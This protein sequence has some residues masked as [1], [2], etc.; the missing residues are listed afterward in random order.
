MEP[1]VEQVLSYRSAGEKGP[2]VRGK[3]RTVL[4]VLI[5]LLGSAVLLVLGPTFLF[6]GAVFN[7]TIDE[8]EARSSIAALAGGAGNLP[9]SLRVVKAIRNGDG[10]DGPTYYYKLSIS[11]AEMDAFKQNVRREI[12]R[13]ARDD[14]QDGDT[15]DVLPGFDYPRWWRPRDLPDAEL[16]HSRYEWFVLS[17]QTGTVY[18]LT[19]SS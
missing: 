7:S 17:R 19:F 18:V 8:P 5:V 6:L 13:F 11:P 14:L 15:L 4:L 10:P 16:L 12:E 3:T 9:G 2:P 1:S